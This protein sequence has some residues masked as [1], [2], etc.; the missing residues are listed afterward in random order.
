MRKF[1][2]IALIILAVT[3]SAGDS[4]A[5][6]GDKWGSLSRNEIS[7]SAKNMMNLT[8]KP[9]KS[10]LNCAT[11]TK[12]YNYS[13]TTWYSG[14]AYSQCGEQQNVTEFAKA[15]TTLRSST[16]NQLGNDCSGFVSIAW[17]LPKRYTTSLFE[18]DAISTG[19]YVAKL[20]E[21]GSGANAGL[22]RGDAM[23]N[24]KANEA[25]I[26]L[27]DTASKTGVQSI[28]Q[29][30]YTATSVFRKW[31]QLQNYRPIRRE[32]LQ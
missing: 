20:G 5:W 19:G 22:T 6:T 16:G 4:F 29:T 2:V 9:N 17:R 14:M 30:P 15:V 18:S 23:V 8:W 21:V 10:F 7:T 25:H 1:A 13:S 27:V 32:N 11:S 28:E 3:M 12:K 24:I 31:S 26:I